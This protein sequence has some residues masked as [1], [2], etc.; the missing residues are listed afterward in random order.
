MQR[1][2]SVLTRP[3][4]RARK[5]SARGQSLA[6]LSSW[7]SRRTDQCGER[8]KLATAPRQS[9]DCAKSQSFCGPKSHLGFITIVQPVARAGAV[10]H[11]LFLGLSL[12]QN[13]E[14]IVEHT[15]SKQL[16]GTAVG[17]DMYE[18]E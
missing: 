3:Q 2:Y 11:A 12:Y 9:V 17:G 4:P 16:S 14:V 18:P 13:L 7:L 6:W 10:F 1:Q 5:V 15:T 8:C